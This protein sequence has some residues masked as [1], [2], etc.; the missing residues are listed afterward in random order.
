MLRS[1]M[2]DNHEHAWQVEPAEDAESGLATTKQTG[3]QA[4][5]NASDELDSLHSMNMPC[6]S[7]KARMFKS[8]SSSTSRTCTL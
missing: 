7:T 1:P 2:A 4:L 3:V 5:L 8:G 6:E